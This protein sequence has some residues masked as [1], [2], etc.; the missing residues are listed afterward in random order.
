MSLL[1]QSCVGSEGGIF[2]CK[3]LFPM[4][5]PERPPKMRFTTPIWHPNGAGF[6]FFVSILIALVQ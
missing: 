1:D 5:Y 2:N 4:E 6:N 3:M